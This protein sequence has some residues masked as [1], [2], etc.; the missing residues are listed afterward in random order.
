MAKRSA[1]MLS[2]GCP[3][4]SEGG[5]WMIRL[6]FDVWHAVCVFTVSPTSKRD[7]APHLKQALL[8]RSARAEPRPRI[9]HL[10]LLPPTSACGCGNA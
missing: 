2:H 5:G 7:G 4:F 9:T 10:R 1:A 3:T 8:F 6:R